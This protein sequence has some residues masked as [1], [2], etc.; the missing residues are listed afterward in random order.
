M[1]KSPP[2][3][4]PLWKGPGYERT[5]ILR[6]G[7]GSVRHPK[8][9]LQWKRYAKEGRC[10]CR[11]CF[12]IVL[13]TCMA[14]SELPGIRKESLS[15]TP[16]FLSFPYT[17]LSF[18]SKHRIKLFLNIHS[19]GSK[20]TVS[21][22]CSHVLVSSWLKTLVFRERGRLNV[23]YPVTFYKTPTACQLLF[24]VP[25]THQWRN[26][27]IDKNPWPWELYY[28]LVEGDTK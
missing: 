23:Q 25:G 18:P 16:V 15:P 17:E 2:A 5:K 9:M 4:W 24:Q 14:R 8:G 1:E 22:D 21:L 12:W 3:R 13:D 20:V 19:K 10:N 7:I 27:Q 11:L 6:F 28:S 26:R